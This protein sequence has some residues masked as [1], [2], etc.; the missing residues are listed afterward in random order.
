M[1]EPE[2]GPQKPR[3]TLPDFQMTTHKEF[4]ALYS[5]SGKLLQEHALDN[6]QRLGRLATALGEMEKIYAAI[7]VE[8]NR[9]L[10]VQVP[11]SQEELAL[12][13]A[14][15][16]GDMKAQ[17]PTLRGHCKRITAIYEGELRDWFEAVLNSG[18][19]RDMGTLFTQ[20]VAGSE[21]D[22]MRG[23][24]ELAEWI[25]QNANETLHLIDGH[26]YRA[27]RRHLIDAHKELLQ[28][29]RDMREAFNAL[30]ELEE[31]FVKAA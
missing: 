17:L 27:A 11:P 8:L 12:L 4:A 22:M 21:G 6:R 29:R 30:G 14:L 13:E 28:V 31:R 9:Y 7:S 5:V 16:T 2:L 26:E 24:E 20:Y 18:D 15:A 19:A 1:T 3:P 23:F 10:T 25:E